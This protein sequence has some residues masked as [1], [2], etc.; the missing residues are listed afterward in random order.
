M[1]ANWLSRAASSIRDSGKIVSAS[2]GS[3]YLRIAS[4][5]ELDSE[6]RN[7]LREAYRAGQQAHLLENKKLLVK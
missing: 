3:H 5:A 6:V 4:A 7:W 1:N 2:P